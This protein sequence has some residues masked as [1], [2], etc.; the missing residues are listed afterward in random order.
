MKTFK[1][2][3]LGMTISLL[4][5]LIIVLIFMLFV[6]DVVKNHM[7][8]IKKGEINKAYSYMSTNYQTNNTF[9]QFN[10][11]IKSYPQISNNKGLRVYDKKNENN[12]KIVM[13]ELTSKDGSK[14]KIG[15]KLIK[16]GQDWKIEYWGFDFDFG[17]EDITKREEITQV[18]IPPDQ[19]GMPKIDNILLS[20]AISDKGNVEMSKTYIEKSALKIYASVQISDSKKDSNLTAELSHSQTGTKSDPQKNNINEQGKIISTVSFSTPQGG[21]L[22]GEYIMRIALSTGDVKEISFLVK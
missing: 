17:N 9:D 19:I 6:K 21:W 2:V 5:M 10:T 22:E 7:T 8:A 13:A 4:A 14:M 1:Q 15:Y 16:Q 3:I 18:T 20:D 12:L 11:F